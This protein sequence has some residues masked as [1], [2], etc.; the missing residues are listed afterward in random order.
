MGPYLNGAAGMDPHFGCLNATNG[1]N[2]TKCAERLT[3]AANAV[4]RSGQ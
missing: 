3:H 2:C 4:L 1:A